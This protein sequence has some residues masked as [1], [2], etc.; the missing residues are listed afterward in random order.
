MRSIQDITKEVIG[1]AMEVH[2]TLGPGF[3]ESVYQQALV[4]ELGRCR[5]AGDADCAIQAR[6]PVKVQYKGIVVG[7]FQ[8]D[9]MI[10]NRL[11]I[12]LKAVSALV[13]AHEVQLVNYLTATGV[14]DG[15]LINFGE[16]SLTFKRKFRDY[17]PAPD[18][19]MSL[20]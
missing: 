8:A 17:Q 7:D 11:V 12:E 6:V 10:G 20:N 3:L 1:A 9:L 18:R 4:H 14:A 15:L 13:P 16:K 19:A 5:F 2:R